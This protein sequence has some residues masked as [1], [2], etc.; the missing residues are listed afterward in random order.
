MKK[1][2]TLTIMLFILFFAVAS[3][4]HHLWIEAGDNGCYTVKRGMITQR[5]DIYNPVCV[6]EIRAY[7]ENEKQ[8]SID[9]VN[10]TEQVVF[11]TETPAA[12]ASVVSKWGHRVNTTR[13]K[14]LMNRQEAES[15]G[16]KV[17]SAFFSTQFSKTLFLPSSLTQKP[18][19]LKFEMVPITDPMGAKPGEPLS[20]KLLYEG[21]PLAGASIIM[22]GGQ[23]FKTD[24]NG[25]AQINL[26]DKGVQLLYAR[27]NVPAENNSELDF[28]RF[29]TFLTFE[30]TP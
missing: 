8:I 27:H 1:L 11:K 6:T 23:E 28:L 16:F 25:V 20:V 24:K 12:M 13:G 17:V 4:A 21:N 5:T 7:A 22:R 18:L 10:E 15:A 30:V 3:H 2:L 29:M 9:R 14:K 19:G 26:K